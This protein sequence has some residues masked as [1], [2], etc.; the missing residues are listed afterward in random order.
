MS[1]RAKDREKLR[2]LSKAL[3]GGKYQ[4]EVGAAIADSSGSV[5][6]AQIGKMLGE[7]A[8]GKGRISTELDRL[9]ET[10]LLTIDSAPSHDRRKLFEPVDRTGPYW[11]LC[12]E[13]REASSSSP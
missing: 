11:A 10:K 4:A 1:D 3:L 13:L 9:M 6:G 8:P 12:L 7:K 5:W 2:S